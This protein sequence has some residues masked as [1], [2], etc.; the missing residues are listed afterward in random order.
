MTGVCSVCGEHRTTTVP[1]HG[2][3]GPPTCEPCY[4]EAFDESANDAYER[5]K[6]ELRLVP[7]AEFAAVDEPSAEALLGADDD[8]AFIAG[9]TVVT[10]GDGGQGK[11]HSRLTRSCTSPWG[12]RGSAWPCPGRCG[13]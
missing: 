13:S 8:A 1:R 3:H 9:G 2:T 10:Y 7:L 5:D 6:A 4:L 11:R 12:C